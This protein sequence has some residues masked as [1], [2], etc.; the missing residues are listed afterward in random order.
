[1]PNYS[2][3][4]SLFGATGIASQES[5]QPAESAEQAPSRRQFLQGTIGTLLAGSVAGKLT[6]SPS[7]GAVESAPI[8]NEPSVAQGISLPYR[9]GAAEADITPTWPVRMAGFAYRGSK[10][11]EGFY[12]SLHTRA[13]TIDDGKN[14][15]VYLV[16]DVVFWDNL[17][18]P[19]GIV[20]AIQ[21]ELEKRHGLVPA[22]IVMVATHTHSGPA[23]NDEKFKPMLIEKAIKVVGDAL[24][25]AR[26]ARLFFGRGSTNIGTCRRGRDING[27][28]VWEINP[29]GSHDH[30]VVVLKA[31]DH[32]GRPIALT[33]NYGCHPTTMG[34]QMIGGDY[35]GF[36]Q[37]EMKE[38]LGGAPAL[39]LQGTAGDAKTDNPE[40]GNRFLFLNPTKATVDQ[41]AAFGKRLADDICRVLAAPMEEITGPVRFG[42]S[43]IDLPVLSA[44]K[45]AN[46]IDAD[47]KADPAKP[48]SGPR[49][50]M[51]R[52]AR[53]ILDSMDNN[54]EYKVTQKGEI[55]AVRIGD[56][57]IHVGFTGE[58]CS[59]VGLRIK[60]ELRGC[61][62][63]VTGYTGLSNG[64]FPGQSQISAGGYEVF[65]NPKHLPYSPEAEDMIVCDAMELVQTIG[66]KIPPLE[67]NPSA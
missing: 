11:S 25:T 12:Q 5:V 41:P 51:A 48:L 56:Q 35:A 10:L 52:M 7:L 15:I 61:K 46:H 1:M 36:A 50:R 18:R 58:I 6:G 45:G 14:K 26:P 22:Q 13:V 60:D 63:M 4:S 62:V 32:S 40:H 19:I 39:F 54:G 57:F 9:I 16:A 8:R 38:R 31:V 37:I 28:S 44:W 3:K 21:E 2:S 24:E 64:Y 42:T 17:D 43:M 34:T 49:R 29:Y 30:E 27:D 33:F 55:Y 59:P 65:G 66:P 53:W 20:K 67:P 23:L 47:S